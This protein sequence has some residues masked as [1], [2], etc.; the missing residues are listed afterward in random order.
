MAN[1]RS[2]VKVHLLNRDNPAG[3]RV[4]QLTH[5]NSLAI[6]SPRVS[7]ADVRKR[8]EFAQP[9]VYLLLL[10]RDPVTG[11]APLYVGQTDFARDRL[12]YWDRNPDAGWAD[13]VSFVDFTSR[14]G[15]I[16]HTH[17]EYLEARLIKL[18]KHLNPLEIVNPN[19][20]SGPTV[21]ETEATISENFLQDVLVYCAL[22]GIP[23]FES[24]IMATSLMVPTGASPSPAP[25]QLPTDSSI[26]LGPSVVYA[27]K[28]GSTNAAG[29]FTTD[30]GF[31]VLSG[32]VF[33]E[34]AAP[35][36]D[37]RMSIFLAKRDEMIRSGAATSQ[38]DRTFK[39]VRDVAFDSPSGAAGTLLG[40]PV[41]GVGEDG[42]RDPDGRTI[43]ARR[44][45]GLPV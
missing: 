13:W 8:E 15:T 44:S 25:S 17:V 29:A 18:G 3:P 12:D 34:E 41:S 36:R 42:W 24:P 33:R 2:V 35:A 4:L 32:S 31:L 9:A 22:L 11:R 38:P 5:A 16:S 14:D 40:Y 26:A 23:T 28:K 7:W 20:P 27:L 19:T 30:G 21:D 10:G 37:S 43:N 1:Q 6:A 45:N 39:L